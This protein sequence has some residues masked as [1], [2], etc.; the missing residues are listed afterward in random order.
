[1]NENN[2]KDDIFYQDLDQ[3][4]NLVKEWW[5]NERIKDSITMY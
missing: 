5:T 3:F 4:P 2:N 1:M